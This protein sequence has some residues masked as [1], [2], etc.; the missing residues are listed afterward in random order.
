MIKGIIE[1]D[2]LCLGTGLRGAAAISLA[3]LPGE[4][5]L[6]ESLLSTVL[7]I[8]E[9]VCNAKGLL[10]NQIIGFRLPGAKTHSK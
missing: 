5:L 1:N 4:D 6:L 8:R 7:K 9:K 2:V 10:A 3:P